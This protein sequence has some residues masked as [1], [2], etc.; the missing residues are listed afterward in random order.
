MKAIFDL[1]LM[2][3]AEQTAQWDPVILT[4]ILVALVLFCIIMSARGREEGFIFSLF[5]VICSLVIFSQNWIIGLLLTIFSSL[6]LLG[7][8]LGGL[9]L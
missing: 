9:R 5:A 8:A 6:L 3:L 4:V 2:Q 1:V 7:R